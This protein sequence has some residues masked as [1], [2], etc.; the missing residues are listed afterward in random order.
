MPVP[1]IHD[2]QVDYRTISIG[3]NY[4]E[5][6][7]NMFGSELQRLV[8][9]R[10]FFMDN[11]DRSCLHPSNSFHEAFIFDLPSPFFIIQDERQNPISF[12]IPQTTQWASLA[13]RVFVIRREAKDARS[14]I[15]TME[16]RALFCCLLGERRVRN[17]PVLLLKTTTTTTTT[18][19]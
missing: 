12:L 16:A 15:T 18:I 13:Y 7:I 3:A 6:P 5:A 11:I 2:V 4:C 10:L 1:Y 8:G 17:I 9:K 14:H 19:T